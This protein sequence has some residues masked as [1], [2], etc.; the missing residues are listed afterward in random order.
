MVKPGKA[1]VALNALNVLP[2]CSVWS[3]VTPIGRTYPPKPKDCAVDVFP[4]TRP[5]YPYVDIASARAMCHRMA[6]EA[7]IERLKSDVCEAGGDALYAFSEGL[8]PNQ[9]V[10]SVVIAKR[11][12]SP[13]PPP[14]PPSTGTCTPVCSPGFHCWG[15]VCMPECNPSCAP[16]DTCGNDRLCHAPPAASAS[17]GM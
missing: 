9:T 7:C 10:I 3:E 1:S 15:G 12:G 4:A 8:D 11:T 6:R 2:S 17:T 13:A 16:G 14:P 5:P